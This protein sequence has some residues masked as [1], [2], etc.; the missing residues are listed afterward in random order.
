VNIQF[1][2]QV[3]STEGEK[4]T[5]ARI[6]HHRKRW[7]WWAW[8][9]LAAVIVSAA[10]G[11][12]L[13]VRQ[14]YEQAR[15]RIEFQIQAVI[16]LEAHAYRQGDADL[17]L[18]QQDDLAGD[19]Y[20]A[21]ATRISQDCLRPTG[22]KTT[23]FGTVEYGIPAHRCRP[24][25]PA[26]VDTID[27]RGDVAWVEVIE[28][29]PPMRRARFYRQTD[30]G[31]VHTAPRPEF[32]GPAI[33]L[34]YGD[35]VF[36]Y[37]RRDQPH[38]DLLVKHIAAA[39]ADSCSAL[40][41]SVEQL[42]EIS[43]AVSDK[44]AEPPRLD[45]ATLL[46]PSPWLSG[47]PTGK[48][49]DEVYLSELTY[50]VT[51]EVVSQYLRSLTDQGLSGLQAALADEYAAWQATGDTAQAPIVGRLVDEH[52]PAALPEILRSLG[53]SST[54]N[55]LITEW[56]SLSATRQPVPYFETLLNIE[57]EAMR[58]GRRETFLLLQDDTKGWWVLEQESL[59]ILAQADLQLLLPARVQ[60]VG[61]SDDLA[62]V[63]LAKPT[64]APPGQPLDAE[65]QTVFFRRRDGDWKHTA[66][67][68]E[69]A[70]GT[71]VASTSLTTVITT[72]SYSRMRRA[73]PPLPFPMPGRGP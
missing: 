34:H 58:S 40:A 56:L 64:T 20:R 62:R 12:Y 23:S 60:T 44:V 9:I 70:D 51:H 4:E 29:D 1:E 59:F 31:W 10:T 19:W 65:Q 69:Q 63:T 30:L 16:D 5:L 73:Y 28:A 39:F 18:E 25:L 2:W 21:Q 35:L 26:Q 47:I 55:S 8:T 42:P 15:Q 71:Q 61:I 52:G 24:V 17:F 57:R 14:R 72:T 6:G 54:L 27:L 53:G 13:V 33:Q 45:G 37:H 68:W 41:C 3:G 50:A 38:V 22:G 43:F 11:G 36:R 7:P 46:L 48:E 49:W 67:L 66:P 32:W